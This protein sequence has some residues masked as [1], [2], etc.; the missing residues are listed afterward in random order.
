MENRRRL[1]NLSEM[2][3]KLISCNYQ[4]NI[5]KGIVYKDSTASKIAQVDRMKSSTMS[6]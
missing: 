5:L 2:P 4:I 3:F 1:G 6:E